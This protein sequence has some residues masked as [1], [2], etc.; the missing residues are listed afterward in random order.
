MVLLYNTYRARRD[1]E[2]LERL[3][4]PGAGHCRLGAMRNRCP[5]GAIHPP[6]ARRFK[7]RPASIR[8]LVLR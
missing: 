5:L 8:A 1:E 7:V 6:K 4:V 3:Q 2:T